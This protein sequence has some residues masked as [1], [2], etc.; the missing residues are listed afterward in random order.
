MKMNWIQSARRRRRPRICAPTGAQRGRAGH[1]VRASGG[2]SA[3]TLSGRRTRPAHA[4]IGAFDP[5]PVGDKLL[6]M[7]TGGSSNI[8]GD[9]RIRGNGQAFTLIELLVVV[10]VIALLISILMPALTNARQQAR[11]TKCLAHLRVLGQGIAMYASEYRDGMPPSRLPKI[12]G[13]NCEPYADILGGR[14]YRPT[15]TAMMSP[16]V[17]APPFEDPKGCKTDTDRFGQPGDMQN[18]SYDVYVCPGVPEW[19]DERNGSYGYNYQFLGNSRLSDNSDAHSYKNWPVQLT[20][21]RY[22]ARTVAA[23]DCM[24]TAASWPPAGRME[25]EDNSRD[26]ERYGNEGFNLDPPW[27]DPVN[28]EM[29]NFDSSPQ[30]RSAADPRHREM[31]NILWVDSH[32]SAHTLEQLGYRFEP[33]GVIGFDGENML[34]SGNGLDLPWTPGFSLSW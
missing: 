11:A 33:D 14:K 30:S 22:P 1:P 9:P 25:Y 28:G 23:G 10:A 32:A 16:A 7:A 12:P 31:A 4:P 6:H 18:Y 8:A 3:S 19:T 24:G 34:W 27:V 13:Q 5:A 26:A 15:F 2:A 21:I 17:N 29:A 20:R